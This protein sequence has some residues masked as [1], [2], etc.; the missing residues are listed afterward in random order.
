[1][2]IIFDDTA[3]KESLWPLTATRNAADI[4]IGILTVR[5]KWDWLIQPYRD[6]IPDATVN[7]AIVPSKES[8][9]ILKNDGRIVLN[10]DKRITNILQYPWNIFQLNDWAIRRDFE[11]LTEQRQSQTV[12]S[13]NS[14]I[15]PGNILW[16]KV[17]LWNTVLSMHLQAR[18]IS[19]GMQQ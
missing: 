5:E 6:R 16:K 18:Y 9:A 19:A 14:L 11:M 4:R 2:K 3:V 10:E 17:P 1:M 13:T 15:A 8:I 7:S 12:S